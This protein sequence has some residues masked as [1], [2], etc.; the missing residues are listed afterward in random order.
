MFGQDAG[1]RP[2]STE[3]TAFAGLSTPATGDKE[4]AGLGIGNSMPL[5]GRISYNITAHHAVEFSVANPIAAY[6]NYVYHFSPIRRKWIPYVTAGAGGSRHGLE[7]TTGTEA[8]NTTD[9]NLRE[10]E[11]DRAKTAF[12]GNFGGGVKYGLSDRFAL[13]F[14]VRDFVGRYGATFAGTP[15]SATSINARRTINDFQFTAG[16]VFRFGGR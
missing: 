13:R 16:F 12:A 3:I 10:S 9:A 4:N 14:D 6:A 7:L 5:G 1:I 2:G 11:P 15:G 8:R